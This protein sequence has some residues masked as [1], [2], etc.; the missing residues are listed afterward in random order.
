MILYFKH[1][2]C[3]K[4]DFVFKLFRYDTGYV[5]ETE[6]AEVKWGYLSNLNEI[7]KACSSSFSRHKLKVSN[8]CMCFSQYYHRYKRTV[9]L[10]EWQSRSRTA[11]PLVTTWGCLHRRVSRTVLFTLSSQLKAHFEVF[12]LMGLS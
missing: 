2:K 10:T 5:P 7:S 1:L 4:T 8:I 12:G 6:M 11:V 9:L 3:C